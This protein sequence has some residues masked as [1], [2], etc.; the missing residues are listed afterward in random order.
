MVSS[1][2]GR[3]VLRI[4]RLYRLGTY[5]QNFEVLHRYD[6][7]NRLIGKRKT[8]QKKPACNGQLQLRA[9]F[10]LLQT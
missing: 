10:F 7:A 9:G 1:L 6:E 5:G 8:R 2:S 3:M 4:W